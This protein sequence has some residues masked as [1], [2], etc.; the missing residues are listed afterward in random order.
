MQLPQVVGLA[1]VLSIVTYALLSGTC[2]EVPVVYGPS[3]SRG[4]PLTPAPGKL[5]ILV[6]GAA[7]FIGSHAT[8][9][10]L[11]EGHAVTALDNLSRGNLGAIHVLRRIG[12]DARF[13]FVDLDLGQAAALKQ[14]FQRCSF[15]LVVHFAAVATVSAPPISFS[16]SLSLERSLALQQW[17]RVLAACGSSATTITPVQRCSIHTD[18]D[19]MLNRLWRRLGR[20]SSSWSA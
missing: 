20:C 12:K 10:F 3:G 7:G 17:A 6:T 4:G 11:L 14:V 8:K 15:D 5:H 9:R 2:E 13:Q 16:L 1:V 19:V 18:V